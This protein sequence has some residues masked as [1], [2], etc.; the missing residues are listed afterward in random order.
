MTGRRHPSRTLAFSAV[1]LCVV[2]PMTLPGVA[3]GQAPV[4]TPADYVIG[5]GDVLQISVFAKPELDRTVEVDAQ[6]NIAVPPV[7]DI[8]ANGLTAR[9][10]AD[11][12]TDRLSTYLRG[13]ATVSITVKEFVSQSVYVQGSVVRTGR[14][15]AAVLP[16]LVDVIN[17]AGGALANG[18]LSRVLITHRGGAPPFQITVDVASALREGSEARLPPLRAGD[19]VTVPASVS[20]VGGAGSGQG[21]GMLGEVGSPGL[22]PVAPDED[23]WAALALAGGPRSSSNLSS[24]RVLTRE[25]HGATV[26]TVNLLETLQRGNQ[27]P[28]MIKPGDIVFVEAKGSSAWSKFLGVLATTRDVANIVAVV[29]VLQ[30]NP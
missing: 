12:V 16:S 15:G 17:L 25:E 6:G 3:L 24:I 22:Y 1:A 7:G 18:D 28:Y 26:V 19:I 10:L 30:K 9:Q 23:L 11:R 13:A 2:L 14:Y 29:R 20:L 8:K 4:R 27:R 5:I 21:V